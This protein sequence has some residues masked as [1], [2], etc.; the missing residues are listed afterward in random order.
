MGTDRLRPGRHCFCSTATA[1][2][3]LYQS[4]RYRLI[5]VAPVYDDAPAASELVRHL[6]QAFWSSNVDWSVMFVD[7]GSPVR[8][9]QQLQGPSDVPVEVLRLKRNVGHQRAIALVLDFV[10]IRDYRLFIE[11]IE[12]VESKEEKT[13]ALLARGT[14]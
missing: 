8:L 11:G 14:G 4:K 6:Q 1:V 7:D 3:S 13:V 10:P 5:V 12:E 9:A 2:T